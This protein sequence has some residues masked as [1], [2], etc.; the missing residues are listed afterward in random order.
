MV[1]ST[2]HRSAVAETP[3]SWKRKGGKGG[4]NVLNKSVRKREVANKA[5]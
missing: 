2:R 4:S 5:A 3:M 1:S